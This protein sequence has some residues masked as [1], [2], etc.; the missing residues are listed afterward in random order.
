VKFYNIK[1][2]ILI[3]FLLSLFFSSLEILLPIFLFSVFLIYIH[4]KKSL[5]FSG[6]FRFWIFPIIFVSLLPFFTGDKFLSYS[7]AEFKK[8]APILLHLYLFNCVLNYINDSLSINDIYGFF[9]KRNMRY[10]GLV[11]SLTLSIFKKIRYDIQETLIY[12]A[13]F[14]G[15]RNKIHKFA[16]LIY[17]IIRNSLKTGENILC[18]LYLR[19]IKIKEK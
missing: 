3:V 4:S 10:V 15:N 14:K 17:L 8:A 5:R 18:L 13:K 16:N 6:G 19:D 1:N 7:L 11:I 12:Y 9:K 2:L